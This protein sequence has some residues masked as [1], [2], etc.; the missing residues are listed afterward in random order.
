[1]VSRQ[2]RSEI[3]ASIGS[4]G[5]TTTEKRMVAILRSLGLRGWRR[6]YKIRGTPDFV[7][8]SRRV[9]IFVDGDF[10]HGNPDTLRI[11]KTNSSYWRTKISLTRRRDRL[12]TRYLKR[13]GWQVLRFWESDLKDSVRVT[14]KLLGYL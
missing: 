13:T 6:H 10:W 7:F 8:V 4:R 9:C 14:A 5:N 12:V 2:R 1:M 11:P 3:M